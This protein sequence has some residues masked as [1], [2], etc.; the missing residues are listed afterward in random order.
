MD[1]DDPEKRI[2]ELE[3]Q[4]SDAQPADS[5]APQAV[6]E[7]QAWYPP[8]AVDWQQ[9][10]RKYKRLP[11]SLGAMVIPAILSLVILGIV[12]AGVMY[13]T[14]L[15][16]K[17]LQT[18]DGLTGLLNDIHKK[19]G[20]TMGYEL[21]VYP[22][23]AIVERVDPHDTRV[24]KSYIYD[25]GGW[26]DWGHPSKPIGD[27]GVVDLSTFDAAGVAA[28]IAKAPQA[29]T[30]T[31]PDYSYFIVEGRSGGSTSYRVYTTDG[32][33][34]YMDINADGSVKQVHPP[35]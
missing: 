27:A 13:F 14:P 33:S 29:L 8:Q 15:G 2:S 12:V 4:L 35:S 26:S 28:A 32:L 16:A 24:E 1:E 10:P 3:R 11:L 25:R 7:Q 21:T 19:F 9:P 20:D 22:D 18:A 5:G 23:H 30:I 31:N 34:A 6:P 17:K